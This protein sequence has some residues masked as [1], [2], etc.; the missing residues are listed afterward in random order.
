MKLDIL[1]IGVHP[2]DVELSCSGTLL[3]HIEKGYKVGLLDL[4]EGE[5]GSRGSGELRKIEAENSRVM[6]AALCRYNLNLGDGFF[7]K[8]KESILKI[9]E[10]IRATQPDIVLANALKDRHPDHGRAA[11]LTARACF[12]SGLIKIETQDPVSKKAQDKWRPQAVYHYIQDEQLTP[13]FVVDITSHIDKKM[14]LILTYKSQFFEANS[15]AYANE[16][17]TP[18]S[19]KD[20]MDF[21]KAKGRVFGRSIGVDYAEGFNVGRIFGVD[22]LFDLK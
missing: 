13:D 16:P 22:D 4:T 14:E 6:M 2:D 17:K 11:E 7:T 9:I 3:K 10:I 18:I 15:D 21:M 5:L 19:G 20:F 8:E 12:L 1:A